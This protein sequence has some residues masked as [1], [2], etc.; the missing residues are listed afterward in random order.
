MKAPQCDSIMLVVLGSTGDLV[1]KKIA[2]ALYSL[3]Q[4]KKLPFNFKMIGFARRP[5]TDETYAEFITD[6]LK[7]RMELA[8]VDLNFFKHIH[9]QQGDFKDSESYVGLKNRII[10]LEK[11]GDNY[12]KVIFYLAVPQSSYATITEAIGNLNFNKEKISII[13]EKP[14]GLDYA[15]AVNLDEQIKQCFNEDH[16]YRIDHYLGKTIVNNVLDFRRENPLINKIWQPEDITKIEISTLEDF[17]VEDR[18][19]FYESVG[20]LKDVGGNHL[21]EILALL[22]ADIDSLSQDIRSA[23]AEMLKSLPVMTEAEI[24]ENTYRAQYIGYKNINEVAEDSQKE[25][26]F[27]IKTYLKDPKWAKTEIVLEAGKGLSR[28]D[29][30]FSI[31]IKN[32]VITFKLF[33][34]AAIE[35]CINLKKNGHVSCEKFQYQLKDD[36]YQ[37][38]AEYAKLFLDVFQGKQ[39]NFV[40]I[41]EIL[42]QWRF[43]DAITSA[44]QKNIVPLNYYE[45]GS[46]PLVT[47]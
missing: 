3:Y 8:D 23:R 13:Y 18:G 22:T 31:F 1:S 37:Y 35:F 38:I 12:C 26:Y 30:H 46:M 9:Y 39:E 2:P 7:A 11:S 14:F 40:S 28:N 5:L 20:A 43:V 21:L 4:D 10:E 34:D 27:K 15:S 42:A 17:G 24:E 33:P 32:N 6:K 29:K 41:D 19:E 16:I 45:K 44:W 25:T 47:L 36:E